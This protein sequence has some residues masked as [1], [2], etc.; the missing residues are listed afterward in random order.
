MK[1]GIIGAGRVGTSFGKYISELCLDNYYLQ[2]FYSK[3]YENAIISANFCNTKAFKS[4][5]E[6]LMS[7][8]TLFIAVSD[9]EVK[10]VW[11]CID[12]NL[13]ENKIICHFSGVLS[14]DVFN[15]A[16]SYKAYTGSIHPAYAFN[17]KFNS[18]KGLNKIIFTVEGSNLFLS[19]IQK[20]F[21]LTQN[22]ICIIDKSIKPLYHTATSIA[23]NHL[24]GL[25]DMVV[26][27]FEQCGFSQEIAYRVITPLM[28]DN[29]CNALDNGVVSALTGP[30]ERGDIQ[31]VEK[32]I[33][34]LNG[35]QLL[36]YKSLGKQVV[37]IAK[38]KHKNNKCLAEKHRY[39]ERILSQ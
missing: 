25:I 14:S 19:E 5:S 3:T 13:I 31:T 26:K 28:K 35:N 38:K 20:L 17:D 22:K 23:S 11:D 6:L 30:I 34:S 24:M 10:N 32:H 8:D 37:E 9:S 18:W 1:I 33:S 7:S 2:G 4:L 29:L 15:G 39:I 12:K 16:D 21:N 27:I 36:V